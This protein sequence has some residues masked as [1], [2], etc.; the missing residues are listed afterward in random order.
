MRVVFFPEEHSEELISI[1]LE[2]L[3][4]VWFDSLFVGLGPLHSE[5]GLGVILSALCVM[6]HLL[7]FIHNF[8]Y[9][10]IDRVKSYSEGLIPLG[11]GHWRSRSKEGSLLRNFV[12]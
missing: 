6:A 10:L 9:F 2:V 8:C 4:G 3:G 1:A 7:F 5:F 12:R 11:F